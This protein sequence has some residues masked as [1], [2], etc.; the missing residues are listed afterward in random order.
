ME[1][2]RSTGDYAKKTLAPKNH[3]THWADEPAETWVE[4]AGT[5]ARGQRPVEH[6]P[7]PWFSKYM[8]SEKARSI[9]RNFRV[10]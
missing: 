10:E 7:D 8:M 5:E 2:L 1:P 6:D 3:D 4:E 9:E